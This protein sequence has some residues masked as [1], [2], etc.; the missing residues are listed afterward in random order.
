MKQSQVTIVGANA[1]NQQP[2][3]TV[4]LIDLVP[5]GE[6]FDNATAF[7]TSDRFWRKKVVIKASYFGNYDV[8]YLNYPGRNNWPNS[9]IKS[10][11]FSLCTFRICFL[12]NEGC[13]SNISYY[14]Y[15]RF[16]SFSS[17]TTFKHYN[18]RWWSLYHWWQ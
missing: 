7:L 13:F 5:L 15:Y 4:V 17:F 6:K 3:K 8:L 2:D 9:V 14:Y 10:F 11:V 1:A 12:L 18:N 16:T